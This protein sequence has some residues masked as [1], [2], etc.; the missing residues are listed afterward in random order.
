MA[1]SAVQKIQTIL[2]V[3]SDGVWGPKSQT[4]LNK[5]IGRTADANPLLA[6]IQKL[7]NVDAD[8]RWGPVSQGA[9]LD[10]FRPHTEAGGAQGFRAEASSFADPKDVRD[11]QRCKA[12]GKTDQQ[13]FKVG[14]NGI[15]QFGK[16]TA[17][18][19]TPMVAIAP[20]L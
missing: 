3:D 10:Q 9:L 8:G 18:D 11:F 14:D 16:L 13:C 12:Q 1:K 5:E 15:G 7:L 2:G 4:A 19:H 6:K 17:Q 20:A